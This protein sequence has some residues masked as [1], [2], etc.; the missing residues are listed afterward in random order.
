MEYMVRLVVFQGFLM[1]I[2]PAH[3]RYVH[4]AFAAGNYV[5]QLIAHIQYLRRFQFFCH[6]EFIDEH[7]LAEYAAGAKDIG[8]LNVVQAEKLFNITFLIG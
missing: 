7:M 1:V 8:T 5:A 6:E 2:A 4:P 3:P